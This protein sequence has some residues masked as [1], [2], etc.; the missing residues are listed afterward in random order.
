MPKP[1]G[2]TVR[3]KIKWYNAKKGFG[4]ITPDDGSQVI[5]VHHSDVAGDHNRLK[6]DDSVDFEP[7]EGRGAR[8]A[9]KVKRLE[10]SA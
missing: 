1:Q 6:K 5:F 9:V 8:Q 2:G 10:D 3:G 4:I 7:T